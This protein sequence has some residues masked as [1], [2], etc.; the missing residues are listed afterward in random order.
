MALPVDLLKNI[1]HRLDDSLRGSAIRA[2]CALP[3]RKVR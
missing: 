3:R 2:R 1:L